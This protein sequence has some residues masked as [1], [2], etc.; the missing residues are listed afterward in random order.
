MRNILGD[1]PSEDLHGRLLFTTNFVDDT[2][3]KNKKILD[4]GCGYGWFELNAVKIDVSEI[5][6]IEI[7]QEDL[8]TAK[9]NV[10]DPRVIFTVGSAIEL[11]FEDN[12]F[13]TLVSWE[14][15]EHIPVDTETQMFSE[16]HRVLKP[17]GIFYLSTPFDSLLGKTFDPAWW[18]IGHRHYS[19]EQLRNFAENAGFNVEKLY[20][21]GGW[22]EVLNVHSMYFSKWVLRRKTLFQNSINK[23]RDKEY[24]NDDGF[25]YIYCKFT[26]P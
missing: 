5:I 1:V 23:I 12:S 25:M 21:G 7:S 26:K 10:I 20:L 22:G 13:D 11:P 8:K 2:A 15:L 6:G 17:G 9:E 3:I 18:L 24:S 16:A 4:I 19:K 14:V